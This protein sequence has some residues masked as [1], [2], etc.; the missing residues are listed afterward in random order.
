MA[1]VNGRYLDAKPGILEQ[2]SPAI[3]FMKRKIAA[4]TVLVTP[5]RK[6][7]DIAR[8]LELET[9]TLAQLEMRAFLGVRTRRKGHKEGQHDNNGKQIPCNHTAK[10][11]DCP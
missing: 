11:K 1:A 4:T 2:P 10:N 7:V 5:A 6:L 3:I 9:G 8:P